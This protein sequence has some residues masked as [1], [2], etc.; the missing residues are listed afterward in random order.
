V[1]AW[2]QLSEASG[3]AY[4]SSASA[5]RPV[6][7]MGGKVGKYAGGGMIIPKRMAMGGKAKGYPMGGLIPYKS[8]GGF[9]IAYLAH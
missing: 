8:Q 9:L 2:R 7:A 4:G 6:M 3:S 5:A 1:A